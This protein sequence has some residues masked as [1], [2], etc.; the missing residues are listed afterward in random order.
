MVSLAGCERI[1]LQGTFQAF[2]CRNCKNYKKKT[3][4]NSYLALTNVISN[5]KYIFNTSVEKAFLVS[6]DDFKTDS[7]CLQGV[8]INK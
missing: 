5:K 3:D 4:F 7:T 8:H 1:Q 2:I 6:S